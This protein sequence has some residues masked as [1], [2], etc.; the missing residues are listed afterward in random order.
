LGLGRLFGSRTLRIHIFVFTFSHI[1][2][3]HTNQ[4]THEIDP[5]GENG[6]LKLGDLGLGRLFGSRTLE[7]VTVV[8]TPYYMAPE[9]A[10]NRPYS[11]PAGGFFFFFTVLKV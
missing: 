9:V 10:Q 2:Y 7:T 8:G 1:Y 5:T 4:N 3:H 11:Y 6:N